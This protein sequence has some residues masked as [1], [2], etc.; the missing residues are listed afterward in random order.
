MPYEIPQN[1]K[2]TEKIAFGLTFWQLFWLAFF[3]LL[4]AIVFLKTNL[5]F[6]FKAGAGMV[7]LAFGA[8]FAF[9]GFAGHLKDF[10]DFHLG[11]KEAGL[12]DRRLREFVEVK[13]IENNT[14]QLKN[15]SLRAILE[16]TPINFSI[17]SVEEQ[18]AV[19]SAYR[20][21]LNSLDF[22]VQI[23]MRTTNLNLDDYLF[24]M[25]KKVL[26]MNDAELEKEYESF[27]EFVQ[28]FIK[29]N[30]VKNRLFFIVI[31]YSPYHKAKLFKDIFITVKNLFSKEKEKSSV[32]I[33]RE[34]ALNQL[35]IRSELCREK[36][37]RCSLFV[38]RLN[39]GQLFTLLASFFDSYIEAK[40]D[41]F[42]P[43]TLLEKFSGGTINEE[44]A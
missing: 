8:G 15:G 22:S 28:N 41:Y 14:I 12:F 17:L 24:N 43:V 7:L 32:E 2:Y 37:H 42:F 21:F 11:I 39:D 27:R 16:V 34:I 31:P 44:K 10:K 1:L 29:E 3:G 26:E 9:F 30:S 36:L 33:N 35:S 38:K 23:V 5:D 13:K 25:R 4:A 40:N 18:R 20:D 19:I 6:F